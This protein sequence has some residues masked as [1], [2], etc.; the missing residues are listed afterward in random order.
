MPRSDSPPHLGCSFSMNVLRQLLLFIT[1]LFCVEAFS[2]SSFTVEHI[3]VRGLQRVPL[4]TVLSYLPVKEGQS[5]DGAESASIIKALYDTGFFSNVQLE[6]EDNTLIVIVQERAIIGNIRVSGNKKIDKSKVDEVLKSAGVVNGAIYDSAKLNGIVEGLRQAYLNLG[7]RE[8]TITTKVNQEARNRVEVVVDI[9]EGSALKIKKILIVGNQ[10]FGQ[11]QLLANFK[12][13]TSNLLTLITHDDYYSDVQ[14]DQDLQKLTDYYM[15]HGYIRFRIVSKKV[16]TTQDNKSVYIT[17]GVDEGDV[18]RISGFDLS[19]NTLGNDEKIRSLITLKKGE[20]FSRKAIVAVNDSIT[21]YLADKGYAF[22]TVDAVPVI[23]DNDHTVFLKYVINQ[24][25]RVYVRRI[26]IVGNDHTQSTVIRRE[27]RQ[28]EA[29]VYSLSKIEETKRRLANLPYLKD[30]EA[31]S[32]PVAGSNDQVDLN[33]HVKEVRA[34]RASVKGGYS[35]TEGF[36]YGADISEPNFMGTGKLVAAGF[37]RSALSNF[38]NITYD[39]PYYTLSGISRGFQVYYSNT[40]PGRVNLTPYTMNSYGLNVFY[41]MP[42]SEYTNFNFGYGYNHDQIVTTSSTS[43]DNLNFINQHGSEFDL[44]PL[45]AGWTYSSYDRIIFPTTGYHQILGLEA[46]VPL[47]NTSLGYYTAS[48]SNN[49]YYPLTQKASFIMQ[50]HSLLGYGNGYGNVNELPFFKNF[51]AGGYDTVPF[52]EANTLGPKDQ[53]GNATGGNVL[54]VAGANLIL[55]E[56]INESVRTS[57]FIDGGSVFQN[58]FAT[59]QL[60]YST[61]VNLI[62]NSPMGMLGVSLGFPLNRQAG[63]D[64]TLIAFSLG[65]SI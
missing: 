10:S 64:T 4:S 52:F 13:T 18:Y 21:N 63:D 65:A 1:L 56:F 22:P 33:Y 25:K 37:Q 53:N 31:V 24:G 41:S 36:L 58:Q 9:H 11:S 17:I 40:Y 28:F 59:G 26:N 20:I 15:N 46:G 50:L 5:F 23:N 55:P 48:F 6:R 44:F 3:D 61:G 38:Y 32:E 47:L 29:S 42:V 7:Y 34:G 45:R 62:W 51:Y 27:F 19:E 49:W 2:A 30:I 14:L 60:R 54:A 12:L 16:S 43:T 35:D 39:N 8:V 57:L